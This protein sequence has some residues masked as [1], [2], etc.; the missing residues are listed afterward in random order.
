MLRSTLIAFWRSF[1]R[2]PLYAGLNL[3]GLSLGVAAFLTLS[4]LYRFETGYETWTLERDRIYASGMAF[5]I[6]GFPHDTRVGAMGGLLEEM[7]TDFSGP[8]RRARLE[9]EGDRPQGRRGHRRGDG[10]G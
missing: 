10:A 3:L 5:N 1:T 8:A 4:L 6:P 7:K 9:P 2:R